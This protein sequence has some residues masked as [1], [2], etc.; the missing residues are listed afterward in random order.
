MSLIAQLIMHFKLH[1]LINSFPHS[2][3]MQ[4]LKNL[5]FTSPIRYI[6]RHLDTFF[7]FQET[8]VTWQQ[9]DRQTDRFYLRCPATVSFDL[10]SP[11]HVSAQLNLLKE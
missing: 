10:F 11:N 4:Y 7:F 1:D 5:S 2:S 8:D 6:D 3:A 9:T